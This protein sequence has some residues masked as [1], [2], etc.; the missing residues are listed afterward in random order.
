L[1][2]LR[3]AG[4]SADYCSTKDDYKSALGK[5]TDLIVV[6]GGDG[7][8]AR[9]VRDLRH[10]TTPIAIWPLGMANNIARSLGIQG[11]PDEVLD[12]IRTLG[13]L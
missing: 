5:S 3:E 4:Y 9:V 1:S 2:V 8:L 10:R 12:S 13:S 7:S 11:N 6:A